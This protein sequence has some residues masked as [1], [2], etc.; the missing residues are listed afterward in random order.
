MLS[1]ESAEF[2]AIRLFGLAAPRAPALLQPI[3]AAGLL[4]AS[5]LHTLA[6]VALLQ[7]SAVDV[8]LEDFYPSRT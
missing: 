5:R 4:G 2:F 6:P 1:A 7:L 8:L 3:I